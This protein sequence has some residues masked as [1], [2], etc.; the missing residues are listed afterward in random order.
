VPSLNIAAYFFKGAARAIAN[1]S[2]VPSMTIFQL[3][4]TVESADATRI[5]AF[6]KL[7]EYLAQYYLHWGNSAADLAPNFNFYA[8]SPDED[9]HRWE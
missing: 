4:S 6:A 9:R 7:S 3:V 5:E 1:Y 2:T 8:S